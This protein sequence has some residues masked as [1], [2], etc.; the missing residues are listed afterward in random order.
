MD[1]SMDEIACGMLLSLVF[2][3][4]FPVIAGLDF[5]SDGETW[6]AFGLLN[7]SFLSLVI[8]GFIFTDD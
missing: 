6:R 1:F 5:L 2:C 4:V 7:I 8:L 3:I